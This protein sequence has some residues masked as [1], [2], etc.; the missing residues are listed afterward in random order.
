M[1]FVTSD[2][3]GNWEKYKALLDM[4]PLAKSEN[5]LYILGDFIDRGNDGCKILMDAMQRPN[6]IPV[7][8]NHELTAAICI[9]WILQEVT[10]QSLSELSEAQI[11][12]LHEWLL[13]GGAPTLEELKNL[14]KAERAAILEYIRDMDIYA[15]VEAGG[16]SFLLTHAG[17]DNFVPNK[18]L[19]E[20][21]L[22]DFLFGRSILEQKF[23]PDKYLVFGHTPTRA[24]HKQLNEP[25][26][27]DIIF[28][29]NQ[30]AIDCG[31]AYN[32]GRLGCLCLDTMKIFYL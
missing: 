26:I 10:D 30:I 17:L 15:E 18:P 2:I 23:Y 31:C 21:E 7:L 12:A 11:G 32:D 20:Y 16:R 5:T 27:D 6:I 9:P 28:H 1:V 13:N 24:L 19:H 29:K 25:P 8:G 4:L 22:T 14:S 3:H